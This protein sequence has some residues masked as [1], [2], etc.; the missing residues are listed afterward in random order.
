MGNAEQE[1]WGSELGC[2]AEGM[3]EEQEG[4]DGTG[5]VENGTEG[6]R[7]RGLG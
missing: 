5:A 1:G 6:R 4:R 7:E 3:G 2:G